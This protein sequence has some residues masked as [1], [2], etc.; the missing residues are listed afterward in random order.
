MSEKLSG[1]PSENEKHNPQHIRQINKQSVRKRQKA[2]ALATVSQLT[3]SSHELQPQ[4]NKYDAIS[5]INLF[6]KNIASDPE[7]VTNCGSSAL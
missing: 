3:Y 1:A 6:H 7:Y 5:V 2:E 4:E